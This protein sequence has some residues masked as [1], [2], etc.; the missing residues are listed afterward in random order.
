MLRLCLFLICLI[1]QELMINS[2]NLQDST[3]QQRRHKLQLQLSESY[4]LKQAG[5][6]A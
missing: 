1:T 2:G 6:N 5:I 4:G 3:R